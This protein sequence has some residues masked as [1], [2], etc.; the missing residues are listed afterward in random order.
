MLFDPGRDAN[1]FLH[2]ATFA[3]MIA[4]ERSARFPAAFSKAFAKGADESGDLAGA[5]GPRWRTDF[6]RD[7]LADV[8]RSLRERPDCRRQVVCM[9]D[10]RRDADPESRDVPC[11]VVVHLQ[12]DQVGRLNMTVF[13]RS[14]DVLWGAYG[15]DAVTFSMLLQYMAAR[16]GCG[17]GRYW[18]VSD[19][20][21][22]YTGVLAKTPQPIRACL[23]RA[24]LVAPVALTGDMDAFDADC[25]M[26]VAG[27][28]SLSLRHPYT[29]H[30]LSPAFDAHKE[31][32]ALRAPD[33][34]DA[35]LERLGRMPEGSD[36]RR[37]CEAWIERRREKWIAKNA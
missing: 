19:N 21:H 18:Q 32:R 16:I 35:A 6:Q 9:W 23:Y 31:Y 22:G 1:P 8:A 13:C 14:N 29:R 10:P 11:N 3:W 5:Y 30:V 17:V 25:V 26:L 36:W 34:Y 27:A 4:G 20:W 7:Q 37:A 2:L 12:R 24:G 15:E 28:E 33:K